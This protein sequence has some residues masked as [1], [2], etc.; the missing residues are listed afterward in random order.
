MP[1]Q[2]LEAERKQAEKQAAQAEETEK[3]AGYITDLSREVDDK[4]YRILDVFIDA[5][6]RI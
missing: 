2:C 1:E 3:R 4:V 5:A 6:T